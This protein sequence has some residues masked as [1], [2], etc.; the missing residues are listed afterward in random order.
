L[1]KLR[2]ILDKLAKK[3]ESATCKSNKSGY[4]KSH[5]N[6]SAE[7]LKISED[8]VGLFHLRLH[9]SFKKRLSDLKLG[10]F[11]DKETRE[12]LK[13]NDSSVSEGFK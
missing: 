1:P 7:N 3:H 12:N 11:G 2:Q 4:P 8:S 10:C 6:F 13:Y 9:P 5:K